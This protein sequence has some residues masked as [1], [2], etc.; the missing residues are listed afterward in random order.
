MRY[1]YKCECGC[2]Q[3]INGS[4]SVGPPASVVCESCHEEMDRDWKADAP[5]IDT[6]NCRDADAIPIEKRVERGMG[7]MNSGD[8]EERRFQDHI[9][10]T[11]K[12]IAD[13]GNRGQMKMTHSVPAD[14]YHGKVRET[15]D[16]SYWKD[17][18]NLAK[19]KSCKVS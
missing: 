19:H 17:P 9:N 16:K 5:N 13:G 10:E 15:G 3:T 11:R 18:K 8:R 2:R 12:G 7:S 14:L 4:I 6:S 1:N